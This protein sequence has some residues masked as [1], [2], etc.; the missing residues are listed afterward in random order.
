MHISAA[1]F[2]AVCCQGG[3]E[4]DIPGR[5]QPDHKAFR[6]PSKEYRKQFFGK[7][8]GL[9]IASAE[10]LHVIAFNTLSPK[11]LSFFSFERE[12]NPGSDILIGFAQTRAVGNLYA[13]T[14]CLEYVGKSPTSVK[15]AIREMGIVLVEEE[16]L[17]PVSKIL[18]DRNSAAPL[19]LTLPR[20]E[21]IFVFP[22]TLSEK[23]V[24]A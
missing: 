5:C 19:Q 15:T 21:N 6:L 10:E 3:Y 13:S 7:H 23:K 18:T 12:P 4:S 8:R 14:V 2:S 16:S 22:E 9:A 24:N 11:H 1:G 17:G 20:I